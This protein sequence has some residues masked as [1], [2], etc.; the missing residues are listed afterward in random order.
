MRAIPLGGLGGEHVALIDDADYLLVSQYR[1]HAMRVRRNVYAYRV[2]RD[3]DHKQR[4]QFMHNL[5]MGVI[6]IDHEDT[7]GLNNQ[8]GN[9]RPCGQALNAANARKAA[10]KSSELKGVCWVSGRGKWGAYI[11]TDGKSRYLG[12]FADEADAARAYDSA[13]R[14]AWGEFAL[15]NFPG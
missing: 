7:D 2:W 1:W 8:R 11:K 12:L 14:A 10:G 3:P 6:G 5:I 13:A 9:L 15:C 4:S